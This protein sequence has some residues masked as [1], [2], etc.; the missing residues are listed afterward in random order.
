MTNEILKT[1]LE[2]NS[3]KELTNAAGRALGCPLLVIDDSFHVAAYH[4]A[5]SIIDSYGGVI[6]RHGELSYDESA[7]ISAPAASG[8]LLRSPAG[9]HYRISQLNCGE[10]RMG[11]TLCIVPEN[12]LSSGSDEDFALI[13]SF[14]A[15]QLYFER[16][17]GGI[18]AT[19]E[20]VLS[21]LIEGRFQSEAFFDLQANATFLGNFR[22][23]RFVLMK[24][25][26]QLDG[27]KIDM[28]RDRLRHDFHASDPFPYRDC[29]IMF[30]HE[31]HGLEA[32]SRAAEEYNLR[33]VISEPLQSLYALGRGYGRVCRLLDYLIKKNNGKTFAAEESCYSSLM[34]LKTLAD[35]GYCLMEEV[36]R[37]YKYDLQND[38]EYCLTLY[39]YLMCS[40]SLKDTCEKL[41]T[42]RNTVLYRIRRI[43]EDFAIDTD[44]HE[45]K[46]RLMLSLGI[47]LVMQG[48]DE[49]FIKEI[50]SKKEIEEC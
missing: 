2:A 37:L 50:P 21:S 30:L 40:R 17:R 14:L 34:M 10:L 23:E 19:A 18:T 45:D 48:R 4:R 6:I 5:D 28:L 11:Y 33:A 42:H 20:E 22:P 7:L 3:L 12:A 31:E 1:F 49:L 32:V 13:N 24:P 38:S 43:R 46:M 26:E 41:F 35:E 44:G 47:A 16:H 8:E 27:L 36:D 29:V 25:M 39:T 9:Y 15:K